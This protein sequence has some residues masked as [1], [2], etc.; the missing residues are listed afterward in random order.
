[1]VVMVVVLVMVVMVVVLVIERGR[2]ANALPPVP[3]L[4]SQRNSVDTPSRWR[5]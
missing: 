1:V 4:S 5:S 3:C 2:P